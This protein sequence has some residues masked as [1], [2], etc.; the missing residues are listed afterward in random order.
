MDPP[1]TTTRAI[2]KSAM[3]A[4]AAAEGSGSVASSSTEHPHSSV[5]VEARLSALESR[6]R[7]AS[8]RL[9]EVSVDLVNARRSFEE[10]RV[11]VLRECLQKANLKSENRSQT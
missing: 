6:S 10:A 7:R 3:E 9:E 2:A 4:P 1:G 8:A 11:T 5:S